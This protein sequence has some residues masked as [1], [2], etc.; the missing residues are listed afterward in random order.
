MR[1]LRALI[2]GL[3]TLALLTLGLSAAAAALLAQGGRMY[4]RLDVLSHFAPFWLAA[5]VVSAAMALPFGPMVKKLALMAP[6]LVGALAA[7]ALMAPEYLRKAGPPAP[8]G[9]PGQIKLIQFN[10]WGRNT[11]V[12][13]TADWI[14]GED[15]DV[16]VVEEAR[17]AIRDAILARRAYHVTCARCSVMIFS[18]ARPV[19]ND[20]PKQPEGGLRVPIAR[21]TFKTPQG[22]FTVLGVH[23]T[24][25]TG[26]DI[27]QRQGARLADLLRRFDKRRLI[28]AG[29]FNSTPWSFSRRR[30]DAMFGMERRTRAL[31]S[32]PAGEFSRRRILSGLPWLPID[33][34]YAGSAWR[35]VSVE[36]GPKLGSDHYP[37]VARLALEP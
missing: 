34:I 6:G 36:R 25:P 28:L 2:A 9:A 5:G 24:W 22:A 18:R 7:T 17:P 19:A 15:P 13:R 37:V 29:D 8:A 10:T 20:A 35:T 12:A 32:W 33:H 16:V 14:V 21:A 4:P 30:E 11:D 26:G 1:F 23:Y 31:F 3:W 27:Q